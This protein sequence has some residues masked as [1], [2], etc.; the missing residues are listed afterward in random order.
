MGADSMRK[1]AAKPRNA[2]LLLCMLCLVAFFVNNASLRPDIMETRNLQTAREMVEN[3]NWLVPTM[4]GEY[5]LEKP[6]LPTWLAAVA[7][8]AAPDN[9][10]VQRTMSGLAGCM[11]T[12]FFY[13][14]ALATTRRRDYA[15]IASLMLITCYQIVLQARTATWDIYCHAF[16]MGGI[17]FLWLGHIRARHRSRRCAPCTQCDAPCG[18]QFFH[19]SAH[20]FRHQNGRPRRCGTRASPCREKRRKNVFPQPHPR[21][22]MAVHPKRPLGDENLSDDPLQ[23]AR[24]A[25]RGL[26]EDRIYVNI[27]IS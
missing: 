1:Q 26:P 4:N 10:A 8:I 13:L 22:K 27:P 18:A 20:H 7:Q 19:A 6:P 23:H 11:L 25:R 14:F 2:V 16:M 21:A 12:V 15:F 5:R 9:L 3:G 17:Y 24:R